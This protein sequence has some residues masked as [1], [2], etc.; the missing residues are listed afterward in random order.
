MARS[1]RLRRLRSVPILACVG[2]LVFGA[3][4]ATA[5]SGG[6]QQSSVGNSDP[7]AALWNQYPL[8]PL[9]RPAVTRSAASVR[10]PDVATSS[11]DSTLLIGGLALVILILTD[12]AFLTLSA[13]VLRESR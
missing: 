10:L 13:R 4:P 2:V 8:E 12:T 6:Q 3:G 9:P 5:A 1:G 7:A 11:S